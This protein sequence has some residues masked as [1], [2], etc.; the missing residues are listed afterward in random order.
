[1]N[2]LVEKMMKKLILNIRSM[3]QFSVKQF[4]GETADCK[5]SRL[6]ERYIV[7]TVLIN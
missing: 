3:K 4:D 1:M 5:R 2:H 7:N 6:L